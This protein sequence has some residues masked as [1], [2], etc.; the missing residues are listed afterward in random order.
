MSSARPNEIKVWDT[1]YSAE[2]IVKRSRTTQKAN[3]R[4]FFDEPS[5]TSSGELASVKVTSTTLE[6]LVLKIKQHADL[7][8]DE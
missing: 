8:E 7:L 5:I 3:D 2:V 6:G 1:T 4:G